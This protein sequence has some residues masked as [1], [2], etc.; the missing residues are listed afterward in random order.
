MYHGDANERQVGE[1]HMVE[2]EEGMEKQ[3]PTGP[4]LQIYSSSV[5]MAAGIGH[6]SAS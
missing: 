1:L 6:G 4:D 3:Q 2:K 5:L